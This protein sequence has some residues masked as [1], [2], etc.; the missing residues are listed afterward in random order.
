MQSPEH[1]PPLNAPHPNDHPSHAAARWHLRSQTG[2]AAHWVL[3]LTVLLGGSAAAWWHWQGAT[4]QAAQDPGPTGQASGSASGPASGGSPAG[5]QGPR[6]G[7]GRA[8]PVSL[9]RVVRKD[10]RVSIGAIGTIAAANTA[11]VRAKIDGELKAIHFKEGQTIKAGAL[12]AELDARPFE[13]AVAQAQGQL[14]RDQ[15][16]LQ[17]AQL[18]L[19]RFKDLLTREG[20]SKQQVDTQDALVHQLQGTAQT[21]Q[22]QLD[23]ARLQLSYTRIKA[24]IAGRVGLKQV[25][26]G[27]VIRPG[28]AQ[29]LVTITQTQPVQVVFSVPDI[30][31]P[32]IS[33]QL[34]ANTPLWVEAWDRELKNRLATGRVTSTDNAIDVG[35]GT[36]KLKA[37][38]DNADS[39]LFPNQSVQVKLQLA[40][41]EGTLAVRTTAVQQGSQGTFVYVMNDDKTVSLKPVQVGATDGDWVSVQGALKPGEPVVT[42][43]AERLRDGTR[44]EAISPSTGKAASG[45]ERRGRGN[46]EG[47]PGPG[48]GRPGGGAPN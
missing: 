11:V 26:L 19:V 16:Q 10:L 13:I 1:T 14:A 44:V 41:Q 38:F 25:D 28:D 21:N 3:G 15:A 6:F 27:N 43:G 36:I 2:R 32:K 39:G 20:I 4:S 8:Q 35:T 12:L 18:D 7:G 40:T 42:E 37:Q 5:R 9:D 29:G 30:H 48:R 23:H 45:A 17:N 34:Q 24:P 33:K 47:R 46:R 31:L 22:A